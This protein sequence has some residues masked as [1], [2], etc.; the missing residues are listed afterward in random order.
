MENFVNVVVN[1][2][3]NNGKFLGFSVVLNGGFNIINFIVGF[4]CFNV[5]VQIFF[6]DFDQFFCYW[7]G[8]IDKKGVGIVVMVVVYNGGNVNVDDVFCL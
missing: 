8:S 5:Q 1:K 4:N 3:M 6:G 2:I 7:V